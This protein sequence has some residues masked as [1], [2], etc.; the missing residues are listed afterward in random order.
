MI[1]TLGTDG[2]L[3][4]AKT[5]ET[6]VDRMVDTFKGFTMASN[7]YMDGPGVFWSLVT[8]AGVTAVLSSKYTR[9]RVERGEAP[10]LGVVF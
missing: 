3:S 2:T 9:S 10:I 6:I 7:E 5:N 8:T 4:A 1:R